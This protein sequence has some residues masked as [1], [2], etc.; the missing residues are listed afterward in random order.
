[1]THK[2]DPERLPLKITLESDPKN[3][4]QVVNLRA[5][6]QSTLGS[7]LGLVTRGKKNKTEFPPEK[8]KTTKTLFLMLL[9]AFVRS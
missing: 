9:S 1:V 6:G 4:P 3:P 7:F 5:K 8:R 2:S